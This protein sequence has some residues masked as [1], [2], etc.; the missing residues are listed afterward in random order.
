MRLS[1]ARIQRTLDQLEEHSAFQDT[2]MIHDDSPL[3]PKLSE[4]FGDHTFFLDSEGVHIVEP[5]EPRSSVPAGKVVKLAGWKDNSHTALTPH[6]PQATDIIVV[7][8]TEEAE[9]G[10]PE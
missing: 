6:R 7:L 4:L 5:A 3:K 8:G 10:T 9:E 1:T 2:L